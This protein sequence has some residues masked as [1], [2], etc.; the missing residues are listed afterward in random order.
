MTDTVNPDLV[1]LVQCHIGL[2]LIAEQFL[3][4]CKTTP[5]ARQCV[6]SLMHCLYQFEN[7]LALTWAVLSWQ[8]RS[9]IYDRIAKYSQSLR[10]DWLSVGTG[11]EMYLN[12]NIRFVDAMYDA[13][14]SSILERDLFLRMAL[15]QHCRQFI[16]SKTRSYI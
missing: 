4:I 10:R 16:P 13:H 3:A 5:G 8:D 15:P 14:Y 11:Y 2:D 12:P 7:Q 1:D 9:D 6:E